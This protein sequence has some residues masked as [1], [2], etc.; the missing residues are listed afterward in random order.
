[1]KLNN[2]QRGNEL[3]KLIQTTR[4]AI[5]GLE[6]MQ[7]KAKKKPAFHGN[8]Y[9]GTPDGLFNLA[10]HEFGD[11]SGAGTEMSRRE[12]NDEVLQ[13]VVD[14]LRRQMAKFEAEFESL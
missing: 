7:A 8:N 13:V 14:T 9:A 5:A 10:I 3:I 1:M 4:H 6:A 2:L 12:G 11:G